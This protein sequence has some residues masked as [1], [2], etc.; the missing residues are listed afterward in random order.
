[1]HDSMMQQAAPVLPTNVKSPHFVHF[2]QRVVLYEECI[3]S[4]VLF[5]AL[6]G[7][8]VACIVDMSVA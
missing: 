3:S 8:Q 4:V 1:M 6:E 2:L 5:L 7:T